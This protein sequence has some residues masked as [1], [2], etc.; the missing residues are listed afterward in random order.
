VEWQRVR[1]SACAGQ[2]SQHGNAVQQWCETTSK[3]ALT[4][5]SYERKMIGQTISHYR[6]IEK[7]GGGGMGVV[8]KAGDTELGRFVALKFLPVDVAQDPLALE[9]F[10]REARAA[11]GLNHP[12]ICTIYEIGKDGPQTFIVMEHLDGVT[13]K[14]RIGERPMETEAILSLGIEIADAL[15]AAHAEGIIHRD[16]KPAN[17]FVTRR[18][19]AKLLDFGLAKVTQ[20]MPEPGSGPQSLGQTTVAMEEHLTSPGA[21]VGTVAYMSPEQVRG[22]ELD[23]RTDLFSFGAVLYEMATATLPFHGET[24][25]LIFKA[26]LDSDPPPVIRFNRDIPAKLEDIIDKALEKDR[27]LRY[28]NAAEMRSDLQRLKRDT[29]TGRVPAASSGSTPAVWASGRQAARRNLWK[30][31]IPSA[32]VLLA[33]IAGGFYYHSHRARPLTDKDTIVLADF[34]NSTG[35]PVFDGTLKTALSV[36]L[37]QSPF[38]NVLSDNSVGAILKRMEQPATTRLTPEVAREI[39]QRAHSNA[40]ISGSIAG[41]GSEYVLG[42]KA[43]NC[44]TGDVLAED[45]ATANSKEKVLDALGE[46]ASKMRGKLGE[47][48]ATVQKLDM[49]LSE[50]TTSSLEA[51]KLYTQARE[52]ND[53]AASILLLKEAVALDPN[54]PL[55]YSLLATNY[56][57][58]GQ[59]G[60]ALESATKAYE[61]RDRASQREKLVIAVTYFSATGEIEKEVLTC[62]VWRANYP[63]DSAPIHALGNDYT[64][65]GRFDK[66]LA[67]YQDALRLHPDP[68]TYSNLG[69]IYTALNRFPEAN[70][71]FEEAVAHKK[72]VAGLRENMYSLAFLEADTAKMEQ[73]VAWGMGKPGEEDQLLS[74]QSDTE[75]YYGRMGKA[76]EFSR[77]AVD[78]AVRADSTETAAFSEANAA[79]REAETGNAALARQELKA[80]LALS[81]GHDVKMVAALI[82]ARVGEA[83]KARALE[84]DLRKEQPANTM[85]KLYWLSVV[86]AALDISKNNPSQAIVDLEP[87]APY[88]LGYAININSLYPAYV[89][90]QA[91]LLAHNGTAAAAEFQKLLDHKGVVENFVTGSLARL[92]IGRAYAMSGD[93]AQAKAA[94]QDF[95][96]L[97][98]DADADVPILKQARAEYAKLQ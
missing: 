11:S 60:L 27:N 35:D 42:L 57:N 53:E 16:I 59:H 34:D 78:S 66:A 22:K 89:R 51:L 54:F 95:F 73:Q 79:L 58:L 15:D 98:K 13:L 39:C 37:N 47:S 97:W 7:L 25:G 4:P 52:E 30:M 94:Y 81:R 43:V 33:L 62:E 31:A 75:A 26:I 92:Q 5:D 83:A 67:Q 74:A 23:T 68:A 82:L 48:L 12:N 86:D 61:L 20:P 91:Y 63:R 96:T 9:R 41:L 40:Y 71:I 55:A 65:M 18:G 64:S 2:A 84:E 6:I 10:R 80:A 93:T 50:A 17:I 45:Q 24:S 72:D 29:E 19:H 3:T 87:A 32:A 85:M 14:H 56:F 76:R 8:Y 69:Q 49:R 1:R 28:Q 21:T 46:T 38:L 70:A 88:E 44:N 77:R 90:G 36:S